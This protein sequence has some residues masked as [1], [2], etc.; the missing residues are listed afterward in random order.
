MLGLWETLESCPVSLNKCSVVG[1]DGKIYVLGRYGQIGFDAYAFYCYDT[2]INAWTRKRLIR[3]ENLE[4]AI[5]AKRNQTV[6]AIVKKGL[7]HEYD[8]I[9]NSWKHVCNKQH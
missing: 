2:D 3:G 9:G 7:I 5:L 8:F 4:G 6:C 1:N